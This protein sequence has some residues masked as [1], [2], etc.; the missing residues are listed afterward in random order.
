MF[1]HIAFYYKFLSYSLL[2]LDDD[3][4]AQTE[5]MEAYAKALQYEDLMGYSYHDHR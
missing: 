3:E 4:L 5:A 1:D 2:A